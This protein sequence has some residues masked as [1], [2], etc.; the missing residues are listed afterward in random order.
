MN[1]GATTQAP[2]IWTASQP[3]FH[4]WQGRSGYWWITSVYPLSVSFNEVSAVYVMARRHIDGRCEPIYIG[5]TENCGGRMRQHAQSGKMMQAAL[6]GANE[7]HIHFLATSNQERLTAE[8]DIRHAHWTPLNQQPGG[9][10]AVTGL[11]LPKHR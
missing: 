7:L 3:R 10:F 2:A 1:Y 8:T 4:W 9:L 6:L 11:P 5:E